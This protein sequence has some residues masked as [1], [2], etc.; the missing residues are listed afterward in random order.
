MM[1]DNRVYISPK[2]F[3]IDCPKAAELRKKILEAI[4][5]QAHPDVI[6]KALQ[7]Y[8]THRNGVITKNVSKKHASF[9]PD[10]TSWIEEWE[11]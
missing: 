6:Y 7:A 3:A 5:L 9:C 8:Y 4:S 2:V 11:L 10:C 1:P